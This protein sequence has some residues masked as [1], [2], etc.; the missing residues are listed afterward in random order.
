MVGIAMVG[1]VG[2]LFP[3]VPMWPGPHLC[4]GGEAVPR[5]CWPEW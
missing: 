2:V 3:S 1:T 4:V 5:R